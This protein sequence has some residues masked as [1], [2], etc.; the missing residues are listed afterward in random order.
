VTDNRDPDQAKA[1]VITKTFKDFLENAPPNSREFVVTDLTD[2]S[3]P[4][5][6][7]KPVLNIYCS[8]NAC[9]KVMAFDCIEVA[10]SQTINGWG[11]HF[12]TY[13]CRHCKRTQKI[14]SLLVRSDFDSHKHFLAA[15]AEGSVRKIGEF[16]LFGN[17]LPSRVITLVGPDNEL[18]LSGLKAENQ[19]MGIGAASY[20]RR[21]VE[22]QW[23][24][25]LDAIIQTAETHNVDSEEIELLKLAKNETQ[26]KKAIELTKGKIPTALL[27][28]GV[29]NPLQLLHDCLSMDIHESSDAEC[30]ETA[31]DI[32]E[33]LIRFSKM[34]DEALK[35]RS[36]LDKTLARL[37]A[38][39]TKE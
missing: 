35:D 14:Y 32:R 2:T 23:K 33:L 34:L 24:R 39:R 22:N 25:L 27:I 31:N 4:I 26:F 3:T 20:Y 30:L 5:T 1:K 6:L 29:H 7:E 15:T 36:A 8:D 11:K 13:R 12:L 38:K 10:P 17:R 16:P 18:F 9:E 19:G 37:R 21:V 28:D